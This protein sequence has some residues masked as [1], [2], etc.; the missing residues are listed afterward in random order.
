MNSSSSSS[1]TTTTTT[2]NDDND[3]NDNFKGRNSHVR[4][5]FPRIS[6]STNLSRDNLSRDQRVTQNPCNLSRDNLS[7]G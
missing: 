1:S 2:T 4:R 5:E 7:K 6:E 3:N